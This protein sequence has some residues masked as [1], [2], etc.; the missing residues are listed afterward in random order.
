V[1]LLSGDARIVMCYGILLLLCATPSIYRHLHRRPPYRF[2]RPGGAQITR[3]DETHSRSRQGRQLDKDPTPLHH[4]INWTRI[5]RKD[6]GT[7]S[8]VLLQIIGP[9][10]ACIY[11]LPEQ[12]RTAVHRPPTLKPSFTSPSNKLRPYIQ[13]QLGA[14][15]GRVH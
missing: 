1:L 9:Q 3:S 13:H 5:H 6:Q 7:V 10:P 2:R 12:H 15:H 4:R 11:G 8:K 14:L